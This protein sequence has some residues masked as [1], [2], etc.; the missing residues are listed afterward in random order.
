M[1]SNFSNDVVAYYEAKQPYMKHLKGIMT[2]ERSDD[3]SS[4]PQ[5]PACTDTSSREWIQDVL[6]MPDWEGPIPTI[7][8][9]AVAKLQTATKETGEKGK[10][11]G[12]K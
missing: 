6:K 9:E 11:K 10:S 2:K 8:W 4:V 3:N 12:K 1:S 5:R 7:D